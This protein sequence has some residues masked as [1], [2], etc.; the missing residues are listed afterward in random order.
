MAPIT[1]DDRPILRDFNLL[2]DGVTAANLLT[3]TDFVWPV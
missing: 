1:G 3:A 2:V